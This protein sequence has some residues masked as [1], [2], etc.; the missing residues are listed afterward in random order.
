MCFVAKEED[1]LPRQRRQKHAEPLQAPQVRVR[2]ERATDERVPLEER[3]ALV[4]QCGQV[5][6]VQG[7]QVAAHV[8]H[9]IALPVAERLDLLAGAKMIILPVSFAGSGRARVVQHDGL[10]FCTQI[11]MEPAEGFRER[12]LAHTRRPRQNEEPTGSF[13]AQHDL[14]APVA[15]VGR[16]PSSRMT[17]QISASTRPT[18]ARLELVGAPMHAMSGIVPAGA[19]AGGIDTM[20]NSASSSRCAP[21][22]V[23]RI[24]CATRR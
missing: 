14:M 12:T 17:R 3:I 4:E 18:R 19:H 2:L 15:R 11:G 24:A 16:R 9:H 13:C 21:G 7:L 23:F 20:S 10:Q 8:H 22:I 5:L 6:Q 1:F